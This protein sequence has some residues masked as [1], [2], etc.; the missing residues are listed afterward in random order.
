MKMEKIKTIDINPSPGI[1]LY[2]KM[3]DLCQKYMITMKEQQQE[4]EALEMEVAHYELVCAE[5]VKEKNYL[6]S[7]VSRLTMLADK[8]EQLADDTIKIEEAVSFRRRGYDN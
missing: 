2:I 4:I 5:Y 1:Q 7:L 3:R 8:E 6:E